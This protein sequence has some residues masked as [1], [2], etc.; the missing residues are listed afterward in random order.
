MDHQT[1][2][3]VVKTTPPVVVSALTIWGIALSDWTYILT[4]TYTTIMLYVLL[5]DKF[6]RPWM[7]K[8]RK[9]SK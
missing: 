3:D 1:F 6:I 5:R 9:D 8:R 7:H 2:A 4:A